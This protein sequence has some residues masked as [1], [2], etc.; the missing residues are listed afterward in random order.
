[1]T[2]L[3]HLNNRTRKNQIYH[4]FRE[5]GRAV[6]TIVLLSY[7]SDPALRKRIQKA[8]NEAAAYNGFTKW[9]RLGNAGWLASRDPELQDKAIKFLDLLASSLVFSTTIDMT[10]ILSRMAREDGP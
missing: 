8:A 5:V 1:M 3:R 2:L 9:L 10:Q 7:L 6:R 4:A